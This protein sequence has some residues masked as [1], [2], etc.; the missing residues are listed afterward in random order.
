M[1]LW[2]PPIPDFLMDF[3]L[4]H[5]PEGDE[6]AMRRVA[7][8][9]KTMANAL[10]ELQDPADHAMN[11]ALAAVDGKIHDAMSSYW[12]DVA[13]GDG[14]DLQNLIKLCE[15]YATQLE[16]GATDIEHAKLT[17]YISLGAM[18]AMAFVPGVGELVDA[19]AAAAV[20]LVIRK[21]VQELIDKI[22]MKGATFLA[23]RAG[24]EVA[25][26]LGVNAA[27]N[28]ALNAGK[29][30]V[31]GASLG[32]GTDLAAQGIEIAE[33]HRDG[34]VDWA[35][36]GTAA[37]AGATAGAIAAPI[38]EKFTAGL[39]GRLGTDAQANNLGGIFTRAAGEMPGNVLGN[40]A[41][42]AAVSGG[43]ID[44]HSLLE[45][46]GG[47]LSRGEGHNTGPHADT[48]PTP[49]TT[50]THSSDN[51]ATPSAPPAAAAAPPTEAN[52]THTG[53][54]PAAPHPDTAATSASTTAA[55]VHEPSDANAANHPPAN[56]A[57][58]GAPAPGQHETHS[59]PAEP[60]RPS[61]D[62][63]NPA[64]DRSTANPTSQ[65]TT[66]VGGPERS[67]AAAS[68]SVTPPR[69]TTAADRPNPLSS[70][71]SQRTPATPSGHPA[72]SLGSARPTTE[73]SPARTR[74]DTEVATPLR[75]HSN[76]PERLERPSSP[77]RSAPRPE[78]ETGTGSSEPAAGRAHDRTNIG[79]E[80]PRMPGETTQHESTPRSPSTDP[81]RLSP[82]QQTQP[83]SVTTPHEPPGTTSRAST[84]RPPTSPKPESTS[85]NSATANE[86]NA[87][88][89][90]EPPAA[91]DHSG[92]RR[93]HDSD[94]ASDRDASGPES[95]THTAP[96]RRDDI[97]DIAGIPERPPVPR[98]HP[99]EVDLSGLSDH[100]VQLAREY[101]DTRGVPFHEVVEGLRSGKYKPTR[102]ELVKCAA[103]RLQD[104]HPELHETPVTLTS[105]YLSGV[106]ANRIFEPRNQRHYASVESDTFTPGC[107]DHELPGHLT[108]TAPD[109]ALDAALAPVD[110]SNI[111]VALADDGLT[112]LWRDLHTDDAYLDAKN[113]LFRMDSRGPEI[114]GPGLAS[115]DPD[116]LNIAAHVGSTSDAQP[117]GFVSLSN[118]PERTVSRERDIAGN[119][120]ERLARLG[121][122]ERLPDGTFRQ[123]R[124]MHEL[125]H[126]YGIDVDATF[127]DAT[128]HS[129]YHEGS[130]KEGEI[131]APGGISGDNI[132][133]V[134]PR[135][136]IV[137]AHGRPLSVTVGEPIYN[138]HFSHLD[139]PRFAATHNLNTPDRPAP[140]RSTHTDADPAR[141]TESHWS[142][143]E[144][145]QLPDNRAPISD[146]RYQAP[147]SDT[148]VSEPPRPG[149]THPDELAPIRFG[150][151]PD[152]ARPYTRN[153]PPTS[154]SPSR[155]D[156]APQSTPRSTG[157]DTA[158]DSGFDRGLENHPGRAEDRSS[159]R[160]VP[161]DLRRQDTPPHP[162]IPAGH[163]RTDRP[164]D[165]NGSPADR[166]DRAPSH[167]DI[168]E[169]TPESPSNGGRHNTDRPS[170]TQ[171]H[172]A[173]APVVNQEAAAPRR[174]HSPSET[175][176]FEVRRSVDAADQPVSDLVVR[177]HLDQRP[178]V[179]D[180]QMRSVADAAW[181]A[182][183]A[184]AHPNARLPWGDRLRV[185]VRF[186]ADPAQAD[187]HAAVDHAAAPGHDVWP[188]DS[189]P[190]TLAE[191]LREH[192]GLTADTGI[193]VGLDARDIGHLADRIAE[194]N[195]SAPL[196]GLPDTREVGPGKLAPLEHPSYQQY[197][198]D[199]LREGDRYATWFDPRTHEVGGAVND[200][201]PTV[202]GRRN[203]CGD[204]IMAGL[205]CFYGD[206][207]I[208]HPRHP[209]RLPDGSI[210][211]C[212][213]EVGVIS[214]IRDWLGAD[215]QAFG[216]AGAAGGFDEL[217]Q[218][219]G[220]LGP[221][222]SAA[223]AVG[224]HARDPHTGALRYHS[225]GRPVVEEGHGVIV[226]YP[227]HAEG[228]VWWD[229]TMGRASDR[230]FPDLV[231][232]AGS[233]HAIPLT[234]DAKP[235]VAEPDSH[236]RGSDPIPGRS[237]GTG[238]GVS[239]VPIR[240]RMGDL[241]GAIGRGD[242]PGPAHRAVEDGA[243]RSNRG[244]HRV[245][246][247]ASPDS[248]RD[249]HD[250]TPGRLADAR[251]ADL[252]TDHP[253][254]RETHPGQPDHS[255]VPDP[256][257]NHGRPLTD[258]RG[259][260]TRD[261]QDHTN[262]S[263]T[264]HPVHD[265]NIVD[266]RTSTHGRDLAEP[267]NHPVL[268][269][270]QPLP[271][272]IGN[273]PADRGDNPTPHES[274]GD[275]IGRGEHSRGGDL[276]PDELRSLYKADP[277]AAPLPT[278]AVPEKDSL[279]PPKGMYRGEDQLLHRPGDQ[280]GTYRSRA[281]ERLHDKKDPP[282]THRTEN[283]FNLIDDTTGRII[284]DGR[285]AS[286]EI[287]YRSRLVEKREYQIK[288]PEVQRRI[289]DLVAKRDSAV[290]KRDQATQTVER[291]MPEFG[292]KDV[293]SLNTSK[294]D[295]TV[296]EIET[297]IQA[298]R[299]LPDNEK[300]AKLDRLD[301][302]RAAADERNHWA[303][304]V[305][306][307]SK[308]LG[309]TAGPAFLTDPEE[310]PNTVLL[311][312]FP[313]AFDGARILDG[314]AFTPAT[315]TTPPTLHSGEN[316]G[317]SSPLQSAETETGRAE[318]GSP[319]YYQRTVA[320]DQNL[321]RVLT[322]TPDQMRARGV[323]PDSAEG[324]RLL[325][326]R[327]ELLDAF[328]D[329]TLRHV[330][331]Y[332]NVDERGRVTVGMFESTRDGR[333]LEINNIG[334]IQ[335]Q[336]VPERDLIEARERALERGLREQ[337]ERVLERLDPWERQYFGDLVKIS[338]DNYRTP[339]PL[340][341]RY[342][343]YAR[344]ALDRAQA[345]LDRGASLDVVARELG[346]ADRFLA[347]SHERELSDRLHD[348]RGSELNSR[349][350]STLERLLQIDIR[351]RSRE[352]TAGLDR[353]H[354][355]T[356]AK[357]LEHV[358]QYRQEVLRDRERFIQKYLERARELEKGVSAGR[359]IDF[360]QLQQ[361]YRELHDVLEYE[362]AKEARA[363]DELGLG[364]ED[365][366]A[367]AQTLAKERE[368]TL[369]K[370]RDAYNREIVRQAVE[371]SRE[372]ITRDKDERERFLRALR[373]QARQIEQGRELELAHI[374]Q[375]NDA[376]RQ[377]RSHERQLEGRVIE[378]LSL[379][380]AQSSL[381]AQQ[382]EKERDRDYGRAPEILERELI[383][384][385]HNSLVGGG[386]SRSKDERNRILEL[387][388]D[389]V[390]EMNIDIYRIARTAE[391]R[392]YD[393]ERGIVILYSQGRD[394]VEVR[395]D[396]LE[397]RYAEAARAMERGL[398]REQAETMFL[399]RG[400]NARDPHEAVRHRPL[401]PPHV[402]RARE[403]EREREERRRQRS[404]GGRERR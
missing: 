97:P 37:G 218:L 362:M 131:L 347:E 318:Q 118:S 135:E 12:Q 402:V 354:E 274:G 266:R 7:D 252:P 385:E 45:G 223:V 115:R 62:A 351:D 144:H 286:D 201:G 340:V 349:E 307:A 382:L 196:R 312:P 333:S 300:A 321:A 246:E 255:R 149:T 216:R 262:P 324:K 319:E 355:R 221:G 41:A 288:D 54:T 203:S 132:F 281:D 236:H 140:T 298:D 78:H 150:P 60:G 249:L 309:D 376:M 273:I 220:T 174:V 401:E 23:E 320:I 380:P 121:G 277:N 64:P 242:Q 102:W 75:D 173:H 290:A 55:G 329:G 224:Y 297:R 225:D 100:E 138:P 86:R 81:A 275:R 151:A 399:V 367:V 40:A 287:V 400:S 328:H 346:V 190:Q 241:P 5:W 206:P 112:P 108:R 153:E 56:T 195:T 359:E 211:R 20:R 313:E 363:L 38:G 29:G 1:T 85:R 292:I 103:P 251:R 377:W 233:L 383:M 4:G 46:A 70:N 25:S 50:T 393:R 157:H 373:E 210:D 107:P 36:V 15:N 96:R 375:M 110:P 84:E 197:V 172:E 358:T 30:A 35:S 66:A 11:T 126:P 341:A 74:P 189:L 352:L 391:D 308:E 69:A 278:P 82:Q 330:Y 59:A 178:G 199:A 315:D 134:W 296:T 136:L 87:N 164:L 248:G 258:R 214:R 158:A 91:G 260:F 238:P 145:A 198:R 368:Q 234:Q 226:V 124:Y 381:V 212:G 51:A 76:T 111:F 245:S 44:P 271:P 257:R 316:K 93:H 142:A 228:P 342:D 147:A 166:S 99:R 16:H 185:E 155:P 370:A 304:Q 72:D 42:S 280:P 156:R 353:A 32:A 104:Q 21:A 163:S 122:L 264:R 314:A 79:R 113:A 170:P 229:P 364:R 33:N 129:R 88:P 10:K 205:S 360:A 289:M 188:V 48:A 52:T 261:R 357:A 61:S 26:K 219:I 295:A 204:N 338:N 200:G 371:K 114:F 14:S 259:A 240:T 335:R 336:R 339:D 302:M 192:L 276:S 2:R 90:G 169:H 49:T 182:A 28:L 71:G 171:I 187:L 180:H 165:R 13:G 396:S 387:S 193:G 202:P 106:V 285:R 247:P 268:E 348:F 18:L 378:G 120:L 369:E 179:S 344:E 27:S 323:D 398:P 293:N 331:H 384:R 361:G 343:M 123:I 250:S 231:A 253:R 379:D 374:Q 334:G 322:E 326:A 141:G 184:I 394:P 213:P 148:P 161:A 194:A 270:S 279:P 47:G 256:T 154:Q 291:L 301:E 284:S 137:D 109:H 366:R 397:L 58:L 186:M 191:R 128:A 365:G 125:Y 222:A 22:A 89:P 105:E 94:I 243:G 232:H 244:D 239:D 299:S 143:V 67:A 235:H 372:P 146:P 350:M 392:A 176:P 345:L 390:R 9:W 65:A 80:T 395:Y 254:T 77:D 6:D 31:I 325:G 294:I 327:R 63:A 53:T 73:H 183:A 133:R 168:Q 237:A 139:N 269:R 68:G 207:Q 404:R 208:S 101:A 116:N 152:G 162:S 39:A 267:G 127:H 175:L 177:V 389:H 92:P 215:W 386:N 332:I 57:Q 34:G 356:I 117:D 403:L 337:K 95:A 388:R 303:P 160:P 3:V 283:A 8:H 19:A 230:P 306:A 130:H 17:I 24:L 311:T 119:D 227:R 159:H 209:D 272:D 310:R 217:H 317:V 83:R 305:G 265:G 43:H 263:T 98:A 167:R 282:N 181:K